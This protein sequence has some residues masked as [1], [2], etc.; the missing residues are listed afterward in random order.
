MQVLNLRL[1]FVALL[2]TTS[3]FAGCIAADEPAPAKGSDVAPPTASAANFDETTGALKGTVI[4]EE[5]L[6]VVGVTVG[7]IE[8]GLSTLTAETGEFSISNIAPGEYTVQASMLSYE[9][10][11]KRVMIEVGTVAQA[12]FQLVV[13]PIDSPYYFSDQEQGNIQCSVTLFPGFPMVS[14]VAGSDGWYSSLQACG[15]LEDAQ[16]VNPLPPSDYDLQ[17]PVPAGTQEF[18]VE[19]I[20]QSTQAA[21][22]GLSIGAEDPDAVNDGED[23]GDVSG[24]SPLYL[25]VPKEKVLNVTTAQGIDPMEDDFI[26][27]TRTFS[28]ANTT[29]QDMPVPIPEVPVFGAPTNQKLDAGLALDQKFEVWV[30]SFVRMDRP[31]SFSALTDG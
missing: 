2:L 15:L 24:Q 3:L 16:S 8:T 21:G 6:P 10:A 30:T 25:Y 17:F 12:N 27:Q 11:V 18:V 1:S 29:N 4:D 5:G 9:P 28:T 26:V 23:Y 31:A 13:I 22:S 7:L 14:A 20:W 19:Q